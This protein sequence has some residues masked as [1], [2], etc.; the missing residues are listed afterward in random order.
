MSSHSC[1]PQIRSYA[2]FTLTEMIVAIGIVLALLALLFP[3]F[4]GAQESARAAQCVSNL[5]QIGNG[6]RMVTVDGPPILGT[7]YFPPLHLQDENYKESTWYLLVADALELSEPTSSTWK[8][9][10]KPTANIFVCPSNKIPRKKQLGAD[11]DAFHNLS[12]GYHDTAFGSTVN[13]N[14]RDE[15]VL[16][17]NAASNLSNLVM[18]MDSNGDGDHDYQISN[19]KGIGGGIWPGNR[20]HNGCNVLYAD[21]HVGWTPLSK[22][23]WGPIPVPWIGNNPREG[24]IVMP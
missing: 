1:R 22:V 2:G 4:K 18:V 21:G 6:I 23:G 15:N 3:N 9:Q 5:R 7:G 14:W 10:L 11:M 8:S 19:W 16:N 20:H 17:V 12:Y 24:I 13:P